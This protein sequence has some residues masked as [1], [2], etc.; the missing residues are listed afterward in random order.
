MELKKII[1]EYTTSMTLVGALS[2]ASLGMTGC[3]SAIAGGLIGDGV[4]KGGTK[5]GEGIDRGLTGLG[6]GIERGIKGHDPLG[7]RNLVMLLLQEKEKNNELQRQVQEIKDDNPD[8]TFL[9]SNPTLYLSAGYEGI[10][11]TIG[12]TE[13]STSRKTT[14]YQGYLPTIN[15]LTKGSRVNLEEVVLQDINT[16]GEYVLDI[17]LKNETENNTSYMVVL[18]LEDDKDRSLAYQVRNGRVN[19]NVPEPMHVNVKSTKKAREST[20]NYFGE[21]KQN[22]EECTREISNYTG[23]IKSCNAK[24]NSLRPTWLHK[25]TIAKYQADRSRAEEQKGNWERQKDSLKGEAEL[26][27]QRNPMFVEDYD[28]ILSPYISRA[29]TQQ[30]VP[31]QKLLG[32]TM[33]GMEKYLVLTYT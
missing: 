1:Q 6:G 9:A 10:Y 5:V 7:L 15:D 4:K 16:H 30:L 26:F 19:D 20:I 33:S 28:K 14:V 21:L 3:Q 31:L 12:I 8:I 18:L 11:A 13:K 22:L 32:R 2:V 25:E 23:E 24:L 27:I 29:E 17:K